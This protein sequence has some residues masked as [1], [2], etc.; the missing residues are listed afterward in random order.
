MTD[1]L[2]WG[3][4]ATGQIARTFAKALARSRT[5]RL[6]AVA[7][8][9][10]A[11]ADR[12]GNEFNIPRRYGNYEAILKDSEVQAVYI[13]TPHPM[14]AEWAIKAADA[15]KHILCEKPIAM[16]HAEAA[17]IVEAAR[18]NDVFLMEAFMYRC[19]PQ[20]ARL[21]ELIREKAIGEVRMIQATFSFAGDFPL[22]GR[23][24]DNA[25]G[26]GGILDVGCYC[27]SM[28]RLIAG[29]AVGRDFAEPVEVR[30]T[31]HIGRESRVDEW[32]VASLS[33]PGGIL[34]GL[35]TGVRVWQE[36][37]VRIF[38]TEGHLLVPVPWVPGREGETTRILLHRHGEKAAQEIPV[39]ADRPL[40]VIEADTVAANIERRQA[41]P[42]AMTWDDTL[43]NM[44]TLDRWRESIGLVYDMERPGA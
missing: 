31:A 26:G 38:G 22:E 18:R 9:T 19:H 23:L 2:A 32:A 6:V 8:R 36:N 28:A 25:L 16:N 41:L 15:G 35:S 29:I 12:F 13:S 44:K 33:F 11:S 34:A 21:V 30:G 10:Q 17:A 39:E 20:T 37:V 42:P 43:G 40:F 4:I 5:G 24:L 3:I 7:S 1:T 27:V 14:H